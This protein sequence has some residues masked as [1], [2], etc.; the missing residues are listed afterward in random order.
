MKHSYLEVQNAL[1]NQ[2]ESTKGIFNNTGNQ[3]IGLL[4]QISFEYSINKGRL[5]E[6]FDTYLYQLVIEYTDQQL[7]INELNT[8]LSDIKQQ[9]RDLGFNE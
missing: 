7:S 4:E 9:L 5:N 2:L 8:Q 3:Y 6:I 1:L